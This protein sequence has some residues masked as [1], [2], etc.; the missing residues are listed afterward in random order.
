MAAIGLDSSI[1]GLRTGITPMT[2][3]SIM[4]MVD[5][6]CTTRTIRGRGSRSASYFK[7]SRASG[8]SRTWINSQE[9]GSKHA[10]NYLDRVLIL[11][12]VGALPRWSHSRDWGYLP[13]AGFGLALTVV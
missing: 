11:A 6:T 5:I 1:R 12:L 4:S 13:P 10:W 9:K 3:T 8:A 2:S 7:L